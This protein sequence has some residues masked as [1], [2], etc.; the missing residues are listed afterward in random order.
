MDNVFRASKDVL[1]ATGLLALVI[2]VGCGALFYIFE[3][4]N[5]NWRVCDDSISLQ[6]C[7]AFAT[8]AACN[9]QF[10]G[11]CQQ[12]AF[13]NMPNALYYTAVFL[14]G[15]WGVVDFTWPGRMVC[16]FLCVVGIALYAIPIGT[17]FDSFGAVL[18]MGGDDEED[19][20]GDENVVAEK[21]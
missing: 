13:T 7:Y 12:T 19:E 8:T 3:E 15:E 11:M 1:K 21:K 16:L 18:G 4:N 2:W 14:G 9:E 10:P 5:P 20:G 17:L 6:Q